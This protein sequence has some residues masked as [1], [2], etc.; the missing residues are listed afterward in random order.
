MFFVS[1]IGEFVS[2]VVFL[3]EFGGRILD[4]MSDLVVGTDGI[5]DIWFMESIKVIGGI[6]SRNIHQD[7]RTTRML[8]QKCCDIIHVF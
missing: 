4:E 7:P 2:Q 1:E 3:L 6:L 8:F 5:Q